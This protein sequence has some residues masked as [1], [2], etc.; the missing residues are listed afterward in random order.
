MTICRIASNGVYSLVVEA[1][2]FVFPAGPHTAPVAGQLLL[3]K[4]SSDRRRLGRGRGL[5]G[6]RGRSRYGSGRGS[7]V[8]PA[9]NESRR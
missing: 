2:A 9:K 4:E 1:D 8:L 3:V 7:R 5:F 6:R